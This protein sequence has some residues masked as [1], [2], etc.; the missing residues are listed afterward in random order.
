MEEEQSL[1][2]GHRD[3]LPQG[4]AH[5]DTNTFRSP[6]SMSLGSRALSTAHPD[7]SRS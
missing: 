7:T 3:V 5:R 1:G 6:Q 4:T 2:I